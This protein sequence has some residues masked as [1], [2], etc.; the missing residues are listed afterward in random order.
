MSISYSVRHAVHPDDARAYATQ[1]LRKS[2][3][4]DEVFKRDSIELVYTHYDRFIAGGAMPESGELKLEAIPPLRATYFLER[5]EMGIIN[6]GQRGIVVADGKEYLL[7]FKEALYLGKGVKDITFRPSEEGTALYYINST[8][9]HTAYPARM[10]ALPEAE[11]VETGSAENSNRRT[12]RKLLVNSVL[13]TCQLQ[14]GLTELKTG[15][16][17]N[18]MPPH[19]HDRRMEVYFYFEIAEGQ[20]VSHFMGPPEETRSIWMTNNQAVISPSWSIHCGAGTSN[21]TFIW[22]MAGENLDYGDMDLV[23]PDTL[24]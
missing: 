20:A 23:T 9:A 2:F 22:G 24:K 10:V 7:G 3:L 11:T 15:S 18:T 6:V 19:T 12:I 4:V 5:R 14:M 17:W 16:V 13:P 1:Q 8:P 21:Y